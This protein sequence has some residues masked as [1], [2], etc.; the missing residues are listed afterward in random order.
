MN[1]RGSTLPQR[2]LLALLLGVGGLVLL[3]LLAAALLHGLHGQV[4]NVDVDGVRWTSDAGLARG[5]LGMGTA[6]LALAVVLV[7][8]LIAVP[9]VLLGALL[10]WLLRSRRPPSPTMHA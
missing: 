8:V 3:A 4:L 6:M 5:T 10:G 9:L 1:G 2:L 7:A